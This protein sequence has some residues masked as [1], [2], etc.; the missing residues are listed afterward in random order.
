MNKLIQNSSLRIQVPNNVKFDTEDGG[1]S[2]VTRNQKFSR[3]HT[4]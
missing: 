4:L 1:I 3:S 2:H